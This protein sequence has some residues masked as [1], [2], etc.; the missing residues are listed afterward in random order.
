MF[1]LS[2][3]SEESLKV[4]LLELVADFLKSYSDKNSKALGLISQSELLKDLDINYKT[5]RNWEDEGLKRYT[6]PIENTRTIFYKTSDVLVF[7]GVKK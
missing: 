7:L 6:P 2:K 3:E 1:S 5:L 4:E